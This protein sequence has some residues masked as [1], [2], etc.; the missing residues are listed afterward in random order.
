M[1]LKKINIQNNIEGLLTFI[2]LPKS[3]ENFNIPEISEP[4]NY[5]LIFDDNGNEIISETKVSDLDINLKSV[6]DSLMNIFSDAETCQLIVDLENENKRL[7]I[8][9]SNSFV[10]NSKQSIV[11]YSDMTTEQKTVLDDFIT[12][13]S[14]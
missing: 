5:M 14:L 9:K 8:N 3:M 11:E 10:D 1:I 7:I 13:N 2:K 4:E 6:Y 12:A